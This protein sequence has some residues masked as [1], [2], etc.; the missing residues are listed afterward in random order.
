MTGPEPADGSLQPTSKV[1]RILTEYLEDLEA[2]ATVDPEELVAECPELAEPLK[3]CLTSLKFLQEAVSEQQSGDRNQASAVSHLI[4]APILTPDSRPLTPGLGRFGDFRL[5]REVGR[6]GMGIVYEAEQISLGRRVALKVLPFAATLNA[7]QLQR[8]R[9][10]AQAAAC[11]HHTNIVPVFGIGCEH[12]VHYYS[13]QYIEGQNL[14]AVIAELQRDP[15]PKVNG[16]TSA[17]VPALVGLDS[18]PAKAGTLIPAKARTSTRNSN[19]HEKFVNTVDDCEHATSIPEARSSILGPRSSVLAPRSAFFKMVASLGIQ[20]A[21]ALDHAHQLGVV[22]RDIKPA[23]LLLESV[24]GVETLRGEPR[25][26][27]TGVR[28]WVTDFGLA[29]LA[30]PGDGDGGNLTLTGDLVGTIRYMSPEQTQGRPLGVDHR[31]DIYS[32]GVTLYELLTLSP[33]FASGNRHELL[34]QI[35]LEEPT[36]PRRLNSA[37]PAELETIVLKAMSKSPAERYATARELAADLERF[38]KDEPIRARRPTPIQRARKWARRHRATVWSATAALLVSLTIV[39]GSVGWVMR[40]QAAQQAKEVADR[41]AQQA[42][43]VDAIEAAR[44]FQI[45][46]KWPE[47]QAAAVRANDLLEGGQ[48]PDL[49]ERVMALRADVRLIARLEEIRLLQAD[50]HA[51]QNR[52]ALD[53]ALPEYNK[54]FKEYGLDFANVTPKEAATLLQ[55]RSR[56]VHGVLVV[57]L[58]DWLE[59]ARPDK[60]KGKE[61]KWL[62]EVLP[63]ADSDPWRQR[64]RAA[65]KSKDRAELKQL[66]QEVDVS[67]QPPQILILLDR[68]LRECGDPLWAKEGAVALLKRARET[69]PADFWINHDLGVALQVCQPPQYKEAIRFLTAAEALRP[70]SPGARL[71]LGVALYKNGRLDEAR[72]AFRQAIELKPDYAVAHVMLSTIFL[73]KG[74]P[75]K[76]I[77]ACRDAL[78]VKPDDLEAQWNI[79]VAQ[80]CMGQNAEA[81]TVWDHILGIKPDFIETHF[82]RASQE[83]LR[84]WHDWAVS[85]QQAARHLKANE[86]AQALTD[87]SKSIELKA[88]CPDGWFNRGVC[89]MVL[90]EWDKALSDF[91]KAIELNPKHA[92]SLNNL[93]WLLATCADLQLRDPQRAVELANK[94]VELA[95]KEWTHWNTLGAAHY[96]AGNWKEAVAALEK[97]MELHKGGDSNDWFFLAMANWQLGKDE[98]A[99]L[100]YEQAV[101]WMDK[102]QPQNEELVRLRADTAKLLGIAEGKRPEQGEKKPGR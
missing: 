15:R 85:L 47:A 77:A 75:D 69:F 67:T 7:R 92:G 70:E 76:V 35:A 10:E 16:S 65:R 12:G 6:G 102:N 32:L 39:A 58:E 96:G 24:P 73:D 31:T 40:D 100:W 51:R 11:L 94:A 43:I 101:A 33:A 46:G 3:G 81:L 98:K 41:A 27:A 61:A 57:A 29:R 80:V 88:G 44:Q 68:A 21:E 93:A 50:V 1:V 28:L 13:M 22:H 89:Y 78:K 17:G 48:W 64:L 23:N 14:A 91:S 53:R 49:A 2:G 4:D 97:S 56:A 26:F 95:P 79:G 38:L 99:R 18:E 82:N 5:V 72:A 37:I 60:D 19:S 86:H 55:S 25:A 9:N 42:K 62:E 20:A 36:K 54:A 84:N 63:L 59:L 52:F 8:F 74:E 83:S 45:Q 30:S 71:N 34:T 66:A 90:K 87:Y